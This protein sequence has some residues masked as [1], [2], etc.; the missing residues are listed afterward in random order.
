MLD[1]HVFTMLTK[2]FRFPQGGAITQ[3]SG[4]DPFEVSDAETMLA[5]LRSKK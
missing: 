1:Y 2:T 4:P 5:Y 3:N